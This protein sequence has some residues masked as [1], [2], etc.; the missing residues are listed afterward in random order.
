MPTDTIGISNKKAFSI[1][2]ITETSSL[3]NS[4]AFTITAMKHQNQWH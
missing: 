1:C 2:Q 4:Y 3:L